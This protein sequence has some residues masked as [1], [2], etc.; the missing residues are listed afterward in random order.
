MTRKFLQLVGALTVLAILGAG[1]VAVFFVKQRFV[2]TF[3]DEASTQKAGPSPL[4]LLRDDVFRR[5]RDAIVDGTFQP[6]EQ[7]KD[8]EL[9]DWLG[10]STGSVKRHASRATDA[11]RKRMEAWA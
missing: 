10:V 11:L 2:V 7:L 1:A 8:S 3:T 9:A 4:S 6:G 5:L